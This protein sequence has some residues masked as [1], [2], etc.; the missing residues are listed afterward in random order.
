M[1]QASVVIPTFNRRERLQRVLEALTRQTL[2]PDVFEVI[3]VSDGSTDDTAAFLRSAVMPF[4]LIALTQTN[5]GPARARNLG[6]THAT[7]E[8]VIFLDDDVIPEPQC[9][10]EHLAAYAEFGERAVVLG[11]MLTPRDIPLKPWVRWEQAMLEKQYT[12]MQAGRWQPTARQ[13]Y[14]GNTSLARRQIQEAGGFD[15]TLRRAEDVELAYRLADRGLFFVF[16]PEA[17]GYHYAERSLAS[18]L[19][20]PYAYGRSDAIFWRDRGQ[21]WLLPTVFH[22][23]R[24]R[25]PLVRSLMR[26]CLDRAGLSALAERGLCL[27]AAGAARL[28]MNRVERA[29]YSGIFNLRYYQGLADEIGGR[30]A[31]LAQAAIAHTPEAAPGTYRDDRANQQPAEVTHE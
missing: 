28:G 16:R 3:V 18:W 4:R 27:M 26:L 20:I 10:A 15:I 25:H 8:R 1:L 11:P 29:S 14:T 30:A 5:G 7:G 23:L 22:E 2:D 19:A 24:G 13:F 21:R 9:L 12:D 17:A 31:F 6:V